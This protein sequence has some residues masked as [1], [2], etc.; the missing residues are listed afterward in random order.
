MSDSKD[1][2]DSTTQG[3]PFPDTLHALPGIVIGNAFIAGQGA[4]VLS[5][6]DQSGRERLYLSPL[7][8]GLKRGEADDIH[9]KA[10][11]GGAP[12]SFPQFSGRGPLPKH[13]FIRN[14][15]W[16]PVRTAGAPNT[17]HAL[18]L[19]C[20]D[21]DASRQLW[22]QAF[23][24]QMDVKVSANRLHMAL[25]V[26][27]AG[28]L[29]MEFTVALHTYFRV[30]DIRNVR[31]HGLQGVSYQDATAG[32][33][34]VVQSDSDVTVTQELDRVYLSPPKKLTLR[35]VGVA[36][37]QIEQQGFEDSV[38]WNPGPA[39]AAALIDFPDDDWLRMLCV[40]AACVAVPV[41]LAP[42]QQ[43]VG[44]QTLSV[45]DQA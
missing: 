12:I 31:L 22:P 21:N 19:T 20:R 42:G 23:T 28:E 41:Q 44:S 2:K 39:N 34:V 30:G 38:V 8:G 36:P 26:T 33:V 29:P 13:G 27:N 25:T 10:I 5:W 15:R 32:N 37:L 40:E 18:T 14:L 1:S 11:R 24:A 16:Q 35:E 7:S 9:A 4:Q 43:W 3:T 17:G 45:P 6:R